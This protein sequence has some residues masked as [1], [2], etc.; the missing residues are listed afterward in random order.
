MSMHP[1]NARVALF[2]PGRLAFECPGC[3]GDLH[4]VNVPV[5]GQPRPAQCWTWNGDFEKPTLAPS[6]L[7][8]WGNPLGSER[9]HSF[10]R[11]GRIEYLSDCTH[12][13]AG[14]TVDL[15]IFED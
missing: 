11:E 4:A 3:G 6:V 9:C 14:Q 1:P 10:I 15:P 8:T 2:E 12:G 13:L 5:E 7:C